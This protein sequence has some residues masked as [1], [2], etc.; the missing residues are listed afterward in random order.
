[1]SKAY[2]LAELFWNIFAEQSKVFD[3]GDG[4]TRPARDNK[5]LSITNQRKKLF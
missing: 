3:V 4:R 1:M 5:E 2:I